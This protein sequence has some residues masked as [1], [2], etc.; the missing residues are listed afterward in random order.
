MLVPSHGPVA[1][2]LRNDD[3]PVVH[4]DTSETAGWYDADTVDIVC[5][6]GGHGWT[7]RSG[8]ELLDAA[9]GSFTTLTVV[10]GANLDAP[11]TPCP[12]CRAHQAGRR[13]DPCGCDGSSWILCPICGR[14]CDVELP[15]H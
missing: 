15:Q 10:F 11:F 9:T 13:R 2:V 6:G 1:V 12:D 5:P 7:W 3:P 8:R 14:R 4:T